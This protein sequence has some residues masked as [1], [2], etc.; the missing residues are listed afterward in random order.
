MASGTL[1][2]V[3]QVDDLNFATQPETACYP[4]PTPGCTDPNRLSADAAANRPVVSPLA[5]SRSYPARKGFD[6][7][8]GY[9]R[10]NMVKCDRRRRQRARSRPRPRSPRRTGTRTST[11]TRPTF[12][13][14]GQVYARG[15]PYS[16]QVYVAPGSEPNNGFTTDIPPGDFQLVSSNWCDGAQPLVRVRRRA[17][18]RR[19]RRAEG[20]LP[21]HR[22][23]L[24]RP[25]A[26]ARAAQLQRAP[27]HR[28]VRLRR[29]RWSSR[30]SSDGFAMTGQDR[31]NMYL[32][33]DQDML[34]GF[35]KHAAGRRRLLAGAR[36]PR[37]RQRQR[38]DLRHL[39]R[40]RARD[41]AATAA[42]CPAGPTARTPLPLHTGGHAFTSGA[43]P[44]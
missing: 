25:R 16:C 6:E 18:E 33:R 10:V 19:R 17:R 24:Q 44:G 1:E 20:A 7:F 43:G 37:R 2:N 9:G 11:R 35:P 3:E 13:V 21:C 14:R 34:P 5:T 26:V 31:R 36:R 38:A 29:A 4:L 39:G 23:R 27:E 42:S 30:P 15:R 28:A 32:H 8:Y 12:P 40:V 22:G 41:A